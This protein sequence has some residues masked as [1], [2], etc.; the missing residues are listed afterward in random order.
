MAQ[1]ISCPLKATPVQRKGH[2][3][4]VIFFE[5]YLSIPIA[6]VEFFHTIKT[7]QRKRSFPLGILN[8]IE[9]SHQMGARPPIFERIFSQLDKL[10]Y[11]LQT[12][13]AQVRLLRNL[14]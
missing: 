5:K 7:K 2:S 9:C 6:K 4:H 13:F 14:T 12:L 1:L 8:S 11:Q 3:P 10:R